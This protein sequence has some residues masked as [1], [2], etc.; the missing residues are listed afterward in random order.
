VRAK[1]RWLF[2]DFFQHL[3]ALGRFRQKA[4]DGIGQQRSAEREFHFAMAA[5]KKTEVADALEARWQRMNEKAPDE[6]AGGNCHD[7]LFALVPVVFP[8]EIG[9]GDTVRIAA[10]QRFEISEKF[11][12]SVF[13]S[14]FKGCDEQAA[15]QL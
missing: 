10:A 14:L 13:R 11:E 5:G 3:T 1:P 6:L 4:G 7:L 8:L 12:D 2:G 9:D 15:K